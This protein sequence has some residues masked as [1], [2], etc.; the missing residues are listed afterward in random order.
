MATIATESD[1]F[2]AS[3]KENSAGPAGLA[4][5]PTAARLHSLLYSRGDARHPPFDGRRRGEPGA[6]GARGNGNADCISD[7]RG[8]RPVVRALSRGPCGTDQPAESRR[9]SLPRGFCV[10]SHRGPELHR[11]GVCAA[12]SWVLGARSSA[13]D[14]GD[15]CGQGRSC[16][17]HCACPGARYR[18]SHRACADL[19]ADRQ[20][21][22]AA[23][24]CPCCTC[25]IAA[26]PAS[27]GR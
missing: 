1:R 15:K 23:G 14:A 5:P 7:R 13:S 9:Y 22:G 8:R 24:A 6:K 26:G 25:A 20:G 18:P 4:D 3:T 16:D 27:A 19:P 10:G 11:A 21:A 12:R 17:H 2:P